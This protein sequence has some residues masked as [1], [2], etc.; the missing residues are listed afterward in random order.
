MIDQTLLVLILLHFTSNFKLEYRIKDY[1][2]TTFDVDVEVKVNYAT[3]YNKPMD[4]K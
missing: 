2:F 4:K 1:V 3:T